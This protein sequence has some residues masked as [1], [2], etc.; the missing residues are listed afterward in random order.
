MLIWKL[1]QVPRG[2][3]KFWNVLNW[4]LSCG[5]G[6]GLLL[7]F[8]RLVYN[9]HLSQSCKFANHFF[10][11]SA[12]IRISKTDGPEKDLGLLLVTCCSQSNP[13]SCKPWKSFFVSFRIWYDIYPIVV[14]N[15]SHI[16]VVF[17]LIVSPGVQCHRLHL[18]LHHVIDSFLSTWLCL[19]QVKW[20]SWS[21]CIP[22][23]PGANNSHNTW[24]SLTS[25]VNK[26]LPLCCFECRPTRPARVN[27][28]STR[29]G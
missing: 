28:N 9:A 18:Y 20:R 2:K 19:L 22:A 29:S 21:E 10:L 26:F 3:N 5:H 27:I 1:V 4:V 14:V 7:Y 12:L 25:W 16:T 17:N 24:T 13:V 8:Q 15:S 6:V 23:C 11:L